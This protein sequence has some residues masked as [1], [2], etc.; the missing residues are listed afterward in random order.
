MV[1]VAL[2]VGANSAMFGLVNAVQLSDLPVG[3]PRSLPLSAWTDPMLPHRPE[4]SGLGPAV[5]GNRTAP[6]G[7]SGLFAFADTRFNLA[8]HG[9]VRYVEGLY[10]SGDFFPVLGIVPALGRPLARGDNRPGCV[11]LLPSSATRCGRASSAAVPTCWRGRSGSLVGAPDRRRDAATFLGVGR[12]PLRGCASALRIGI[13][14]ADHWW[15]AVMGRL[16][17]GSTA[18]GWCATLGARPASPAGRR[19]RQL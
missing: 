2:G 5:A 9:E 18:P 17:P 7:V 8:P 1:S 14:R 10:V 6:A 15:L 13:G 16:K 19:P 4:S 11:N 12:P 3:I